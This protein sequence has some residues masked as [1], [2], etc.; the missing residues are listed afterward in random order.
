VS[1]FRSSWQG[2]SFQKSFPI[3]DVLC[4]GGNKFCSLTSWLTKTPCYTVCVKNCGPHSQFVPIAG[5]GRERVVLIKSLITWNRKR[6]AWG[7]VAKFELKISADNN[8]TF[9]IM[10]RYN[11]IAFNITFIF[12]W[13]HH[14]IL[15][16][17]LLPIVPASWWTTKTRAASSW[18][19][20]LMITEET[21]FHQKQGLTSLRK[22]VWQVR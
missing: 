13:R 15:D 18:T 9:N 16:V 11:I 2:P 20:T 10:W 8:V 12:L 14:Y 17:E 4:L 1:F 5:W 6:R 7:A 22:F 21:L 3:D 19:S